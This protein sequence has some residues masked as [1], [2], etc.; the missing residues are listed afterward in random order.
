MSDLKLYGAQF[1]GIEAIHYFVATSYD[2]A[3]SDAELFANKT[4]YL[5][6]LGLVAGMIY[7]DFHREIAR[8]KDEYVDTQRQDNEANEQSNG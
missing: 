4:N 7:I 5:I 1:L 2:E 8:L 6:G 3:K